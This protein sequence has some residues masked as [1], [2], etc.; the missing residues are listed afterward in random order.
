MSKAIT[1][2]VFIP[3][4]A[5]KAVWALITD[6]EHLQ[7]WFCEQAE[8]DLPS[9]LYRFWGKYTPDAPCPLSEH[10]QLGEHRLPDAHGA[11]ALLTYTWQL[12]GQE[13]SVTV[14]LGAQDGGTLV[15]VLHSA[16]GERMNSKGAVHDFW[17][18]VLEALRLLALT[19]KAQSL[20]EYGPKPGTS[21]LVEVDIAAPRESIFRCLIEPEWMSKL[22]LDKNITVEPRVG[23]VYDYGWKEGGPRR[24]T[25]LDPP[26]LLAFTWIYPPETEETIVTW[27]LA[28]LG[29][30]FTRL[31]LE[32]SG[33]AADY[34]DEE[35]R[36]GWF[37]F[38]AIIKGICE[39][40]E[41]WRRVSVKGVAHGG[42]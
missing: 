31:S 36:A 2:T 23:G 28:D 10:V 34:D 4:I 32:H 12:R 22:W 29:G 14:T 7:R 26:N 24:I 35:Y 6:A 37:S 8:A 20:P 27:R 41:R 39:L 5:P 30:G 15:G 13:T 1:A 11:G 25:A 21:L 18:T 19:G 40:G 9:G 38:L 33:F 16:L 42:A 3:G 17:Y